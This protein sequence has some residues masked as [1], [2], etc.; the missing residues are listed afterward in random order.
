MSEKAA[1]RTLDLAERFQYPLS[2]GHTAFRDMPP[3]PNVEPKPVDENSRSTQ[4][5]LR[6]G[7]LG[8]VM[9]L[10]WAGAN[11]GTYL[12]GFRY[13]MQLRNERKDPLPSMSLGSDLNGLEEMPHPRFNP[14]VDAKRPGTLDET[15]WK[16]RVCYAGQRCGDNAPLQ[17]YRFAQ[18]RPYDYNVDGVAHIGLYPDIYQDL[19]NLGM[20][21]KERSEFFGAAEAFGRMWDKIEVQKGRVR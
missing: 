21:V 5:L 9:G 15:L 14:K 1:N 10:G 6:L 8:S 2:S 7:R 12:M 17:Q 3:L 4:Q 11:A 16:K 18:S 20:T 13:G 19:K